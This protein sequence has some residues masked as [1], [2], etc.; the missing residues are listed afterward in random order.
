MNIF[1]RS[2]HDTLQ[3]E[4][5]FRAFENF[6]QAIEVIELERRSRNDQ[7]NLKF[8]FPKESITKIEWIEET[9]HMV[10]QPSV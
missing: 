1:M 6:I 4:V 7:N 10:T 3:F 9:T 5:A 8:T 2:K